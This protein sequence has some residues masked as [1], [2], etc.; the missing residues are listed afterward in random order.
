MSET[1][2]LALRLDPAVGHALDDLA[3]ACGCPPEDLAQE[4]VRRYLR[5]EAERVRGV[6]ERLSVAHA[7]LLRRLGE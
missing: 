1:Y 3:D 2:E 4:A 7:D 6:A 5:E